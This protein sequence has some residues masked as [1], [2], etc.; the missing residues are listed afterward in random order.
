MDVGEQRFG[1]SWLCSISSA[2]LSDLRAQIAGSGDRFE[3]AEIDAERG[4]TDMVHADASLRLEWT[5]SGPPG[6]KCQRSA[7]QRSPGKFPV[8][9]F[10]G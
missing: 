2:T 9:H 5:I 4:K 8:C 7:G 3:A 10:A 6:R 1:N